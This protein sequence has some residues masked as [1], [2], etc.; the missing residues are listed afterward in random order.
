MTIP[1]MHRA[2]VKPTDA[3]LCNLYQQAGNTAQ[4]GILVD[5]STMMSHADA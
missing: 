1:K 4:T 3:R 2:Q 5:V